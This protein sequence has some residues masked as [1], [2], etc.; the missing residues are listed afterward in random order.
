MYLVAMQE[1]IVKTT[2]M[3][4]KNETVKVFESYTA[5]WTVIVKSRRKQ[6]QK[7]FSRATKIT[8]YAQNTFFSQNDNVGLVDLRHETRLPPF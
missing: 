5:T 8:A 1:F 6:L 3:R 2:Y 7:W 4:T